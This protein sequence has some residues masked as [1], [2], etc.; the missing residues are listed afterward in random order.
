[1]IE[2]KRKREKAG[3]RLARGLIR[4]VVHV[5]TGREERI[6]EF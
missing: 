6:Y 5:D 3:E 2:F 1:M 4:N